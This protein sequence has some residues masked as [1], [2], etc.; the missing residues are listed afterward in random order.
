MWDDSASHAEGKW[1]S[2]LWFVSNSYFWLLVDFETDQCWPSSGGLTLSLW[3]Q[4]SGIFTCDTAKGLV[5]HSSSSKRR[6]SRRRRSNRR[7]RSKNNHH[8]NLLIAFYWSG[9]ELYALPVLTHKDPELNIKIVPFCKIIKIEA[10]RL[11]N[12]QTEAREVS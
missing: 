6:R 8:H 4:A 5:Q 2:A 10:L 3:D 11:G 1:A 12:A 9:N 7:R